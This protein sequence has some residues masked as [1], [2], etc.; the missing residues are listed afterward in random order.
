[1]VDI[2]QFSKN[3]RKRGSQVENGASVLVK[4]V[5]KKILKELCFTSPAKTGRT[6][7]N[8][9]VSIGGRTRS[10][11]EPYAPAP[12]GVTL[13]M[14]E[15]ANAT[16]AYNVGKAKIDGISGPI[17]KSITISNSVPYLQRLNDGY[18]NQ[19]AAGF[20][21]RA[22]DQGRGLIPQFRVFSDEYGPEE[23]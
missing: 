6:R 3:M 7:S 11:I 18:T 9:R 5:S 13:G 16:A 22:V 15:R 23:E 17:R 12:K 2:V 20:I 1:M 10:V 21:E 4:R 8:Y 14:G 19:T